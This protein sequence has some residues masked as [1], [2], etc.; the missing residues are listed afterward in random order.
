VELDRNAAVSDM[1][2]PNSDDRAH[3]V[4]CRVGVA[5]DRVEL[6]FEDLRV[7]ATAESA[8][9]VLPSIWN[10]YRNFFEVG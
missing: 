9:R 6:R 5:L 1:R 2:V 3:A 7:S 4:C 8:G 10:S